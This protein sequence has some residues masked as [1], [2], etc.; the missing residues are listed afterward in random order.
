MLGLSRGQP[1]VD[2]PPFITAL[3]IL[4]TVGL[5]YDVF[6]D[7]EKRWAIMETLATVEPVST[8]FAW[9][10]SMKTQ[11]ASPFRVFRYPKECRDCGHPLSAEGNGDDSSLM[12][13]CFPIGSC[14][15]SIRGERVWCRD[16]SLHLPLHHGHSLAGPGPFSEF[17]QTGSAATRAE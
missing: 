15:D 12:E 5:L 14:G 7:A 6:H 10:C 16:V 2:E 8:A 13:G 4:V 3:P 11:A 9:K 17:V 1:G